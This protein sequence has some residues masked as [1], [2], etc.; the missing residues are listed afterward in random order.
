VVNP[1]PKPAKKPDRREYTLMVVPHHG[2][3]VLSVRIPMKILKYGVGVLSVVAL[4]MGGMFINYRS[5]VNTAHAEKAELEKLRQV[6]NFQVKQIEQLAKA[7]TTLQEDMVRLNKLDAEVRRMLTS[8]ESGTV[9]RS[10]IIRPSTGHS[11]QGGIAGPP[12]VEDLNKLV[13]DMQSTAKAREQSLKNLRDTLAERN[14]RIAATPSIWPTNGDVTS[15]FGWRSSPWG[16]G[17]DWHPGIDIAN[18]VGTPIEATATGY[19]VFSGWYGGYGKM[20]QIDHGN[21]IETIY[22][23][24]SENGVE[25]GQYVKKGEVIG[26]MGNTGA[27]TGPHVHYEV[28]VNGTAVNPANFL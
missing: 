17:S 24:N 18:D 28:R 15:R 8:E 14:A 23:H 21:G 4:I 5:T 20:I 10:G 11:G 26:Y 25:V 7:T 22:A 9:S 12:K 6:N 16:W 19:V 13:E 3:A 2:K 27:S 1:L